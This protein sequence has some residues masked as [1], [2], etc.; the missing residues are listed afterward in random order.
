MQKKA[1]SL[2]ADN[3]ELRNLKSLSVVSDPNKSKPLAAEVAEFGAQTDEIV[4][5]GFLA[6]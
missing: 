6:D 1:D 5:Q 4:W 3:A 2:L